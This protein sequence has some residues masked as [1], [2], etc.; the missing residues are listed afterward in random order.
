MQQY[1]ALLREV[2]IEGTWQANRTGTDAL[3]IPGAMMKF[4]LQKGFPIL[5]TKKVHW[6]A[7]IG[8]LCCFLRG[9]NDAAIFRAFNCNIWNA[10]ANENKQWLDNPNRAGVDDLGRIYG[11]QWRD[12]KGKVFGVETSDPI[13]V[14]HDSIDQVVEAAL[15]IKHD[16]TNRRI[17]ISGWRPDEFDRMALPPC[18]VLYQF[19]VNVEKGELNLCMY[20]RSCDMFL[21]VPFNMASASAFL[22]YM[23]T[24]T[25]L[26]PRWFTHF[27]ADTHIY[28]NHVDQ[29]DELLSRVPDRELP[30]LE[31][32]PAYRVRGKYPETREDFAH[33]FDNIN[34]DHFT[35]LNYNPQA[36]IK[37]PMAV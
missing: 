23:A 29:V 36:A 9:V 31:I 7:V 8:E 6:P 3:S 13:V 37:A 30:T 14:H 20:Q 18:H 21:G 2:L 10:N 22:M 15:K 34:P 4:D 5:T 33:M 1:H 16:P 28:R 32:R 35:L 27:L 25:N 19:I 11:V 24:I 17:I 26:K 12:W